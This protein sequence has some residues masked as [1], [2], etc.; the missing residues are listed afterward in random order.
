MRKNYIHAEKID[1]ELM[2]S[3]ALGLSTNHVEEEIKTNDGIWAPDSGPC[4]QTEQTE[5]CSLPPGSKYFS[6][7][8]REKVR[9]S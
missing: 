8:E 3:H 9:I 6:W 2:W 4:E 5:V 7:K 1:R